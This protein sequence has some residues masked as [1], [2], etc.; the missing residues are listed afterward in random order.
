MATSKN[1]KLET[2]WRDSHAKTILLE[3][4]MAPGTIPLTS[5][6]MQP[7]DVYKMHEEFKKFKYTNFRTNLNNLRKDF[8]ERKQKSTFDETALKT[9]VKSCNVVPKPRMATPSGQKLMHQSFL[10]VT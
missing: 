7:K 8:I 4:L 10:Q 3:G 1:N 6:E 5:K 9:I 2:N